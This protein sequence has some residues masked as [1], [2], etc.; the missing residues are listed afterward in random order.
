MKQKQPIK[1]WFHR[2]KKVQRWAFV[3]RDEYTIKA[4][5][6]W[7]RARS[8]YKFF[9]IQ[10]RFAVIK[11]N[12]KVIDI[13][14]APW[15]FLQALWK[16]VKDEIII[17]VDIQKIKPLWNANIKTIVNDIF[18]YEWLSQK[19]IN[20]VWDDQFDVITSDI[21]PNTTWVFDVDQYASVE[22]NIAIC[23]FSDR[24]LRKWWDMILKVF[25]WEDF[26]ELVQEVKKR[27]NEM[28][29]YKPRA[30]RD[31]SHEEY[32]ICLGRR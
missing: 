14:A 25:Q 24:F 30:C 20:L 22:L 16:I 8:V 29:T 11:P 32:V 23:K 4:Q 19:V 1:T 18:D 26:Y 5:K 21:A 27:F 6:E 3:V 10:E 31:S 13:W 2:K 12:S 7:Y 28:K 17:W 9:E 15:S